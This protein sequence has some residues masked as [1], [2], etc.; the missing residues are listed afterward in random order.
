MIPSRRARIATALGCLIA[1]SAL[2]PPLHS[3]PADRAAGDASAALVELRLEDATRHVSALEAAAPDDPTTHALRGVLDFHLGDYASAASHLER[4]GSSPMA[5]ALVETARAT[6][7]M[8]APYERTASA[9]GRYLVFVA[10]GPDRAIVPYA[11]ETL[12]AADERLTEILGY[13]APGPLRLEI[14]PDAASLARVSSL[15]E[16]DIA[17]SGTIAL[18]K[19]DR[20]MVTSPRAL[21]HGYPWADT[22]AHE[23]VHLLLA[24]A[25]RDRAP[26]WMQEGI[27]KFLERSYRTGRPTGELEAVSQGIL[28][29]AAS[30]GAL[31]PFERLHPSIALLPS[32]RDAA[33][34]FAQVAT[35]MDVFHR[36]YGDA[37]LRDVIRR[38]AEGTDARDAFGAAAQLSF[39]EL[40]RRWRDHVR[41]IPA[42]PTARLLPRR[43]VAPGADA[44]QRAAEELAEVGEAARRRLR[45]GDLLFGRRRHR[46]SMVEYADA[47]EV[48]PEDPIVAARYARAALASGRALEAANALEALV[49]RHPDYA[50]GTALLATALAAAGREESAVAMARRAIRLN[51]FD[52]APH[53]VLSE[54]GPAHVSEETRTRESVACQSLGR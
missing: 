28:H 35:F 3:Q 42:P 8:L 11:L 39:H 24:R 19:W 43:L 25:S 18:C 37:G 31:L 10:P 53:C 49:A 2:P 5:E 20:L 34:A 13:R 12:Q 16:V 41:T 54:A 51:P 47:L 32:Q 33:L 9:D 38:V 21:L 30:E 50:P 6:R 17:R 15:T 26:V 22:I 48:A 52:P 40:E 27:A 29:R 1:V 36:R 14:Y 46:A 4:A 7:D 23:L 45:L 44:D